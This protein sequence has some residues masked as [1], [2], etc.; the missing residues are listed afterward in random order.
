MISESP[1]A[2]PLAPYLYLK[3]L[4]LISDCS[5][6]PTGLKRVVD[7]FHLSSSKLSTQECPPSSFGNVIFPQVK[8]LR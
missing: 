3:C 1:Y 2:S 4:P 7:P 8:C 5:S 6:S